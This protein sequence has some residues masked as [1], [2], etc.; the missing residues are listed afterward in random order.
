MRVKRGKI[1]QSD[2]HE[3]LCTK[4]PDVFP[5]HTSVDSQLKSPFALFTIPL[6]FYH[7]LQPS[8]IRQQR[9]G[10]RKPASSRGREKGRE[11]GRVT[12]TYSWG[13][14]HMSSG[15]GF[16]WWSGRKKEHVASCRAYNTVDHLGSPYTNMCSLHIFLRLLPSSEMT[17]V[18]TIKTGY[19]T[20][21][22]FLHQPNCFN[23]TE[24]QRN[25]CLSVQNFGTQG[26]EQI[27][28]LH[29]YLHQIFLP[30]IGCL[31]QLCVTTVYK[32]KIPKRSKVR[33][34]KS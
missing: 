25:P 30:V 9:E 1:R 17:N 2:S 7:S 4:D 32:L 6:S 21:V 16:D 5:S 33:A 26:I 24:H 29:A 23:T 27:S 34:F 8:R 13:R 10:M 3:D 18:E 19:R 15:Q 14:G 11:K 12:Q 28:M 20:S 22:L 31:M